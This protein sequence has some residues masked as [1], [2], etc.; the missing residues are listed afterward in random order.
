MRNVPVALTPLSTL[1]NGS[2]PLAYS[3]TLAPYM[4]GYSLSPILGYSLFLE[5]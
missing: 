5:C 1:S 4:L 2:Q 3:C